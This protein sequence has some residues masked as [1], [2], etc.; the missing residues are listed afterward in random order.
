[1]N[2]YIVSIAD[3]YAEQVWIETYLARNLNDC[4]EKIMESLINQY[5]FDEFG[6]WQEFVEF[7]N[8]H[9]IIISNIID[10][11]TL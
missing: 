1:M 3:M 11:E 10:I 7:L 9:E 5:E 4:Q 8:D 2:K 6:S